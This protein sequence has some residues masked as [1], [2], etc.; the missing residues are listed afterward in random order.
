MVYWSLTS[1]LF[2]TLSI[3]CFLAIIMT[4]SIFRILRKVDSQAIDLH[5]D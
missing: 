2:G 3:G 5:I 4:L 1:A